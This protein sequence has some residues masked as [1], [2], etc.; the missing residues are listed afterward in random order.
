MNPPLITYITTCKGRLE[1]LR[2]SLPRVASQ[3]QVQAIVVDYDC[4]EGAGEWVE[5]N[6][7]QVRVVRVINE[8]GFSLTRARNAGAEAADTPWLAFFDAD[9]LISDDFF[10]GLGEC[11]AEGHHY[12]ADPP[13]LQTWGSVVCERETF[14]KV[15]GYDTVY[16]GW[17]GEDDDFYSMLE[18]AGSKGAHMDGRGLSEIDHDDEARTRFQ[19]EAKLASHQRNQVYRFVKLD[20]MRLG[21]TCLPMS[22]REQLYGQICSSLEAHRKAGKQSL[23]I[24]VKVPDLTIRHPKDSAGANSR[25]VTQ[26][27]RNINYN[28]SWDFDLT[29]M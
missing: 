11:L 2:Q 5:R 18:F 26:I 29:G 14:L 13:S 25:P 24:R 16:R 20:I 19:S 22:L 4:P 15:G 10:R 27:V 23:T 8:P 17:G 9:I 3:P 1:H 28:L 7:P 6:F 21:G 12:R